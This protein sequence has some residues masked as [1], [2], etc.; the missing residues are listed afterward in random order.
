M[1]IRAREGGPPLHPLPRRPARLGASTSTSGR[2][3]RGGRG[4][5]PR[6]AT[7]PRAS[8]TPTRSSRPGGRARIACWP[9]PRA[10]RA[11]TSCRTSSLCSSRPAADSLLAEAT[12][13]FG[14]HG[15]TAGRWLTDLLRDE[16]GMEADHFDFGR[17]AVYALDP[18]IRPEQRAGV[19]LFARP[20]TPRRATSWRRSRSTCSRRAT[21]RWRSTYTAASWTP[22]R[23]ARPS[24][25]CSRRSSSTTSTTAASPGSC[26][27]RPT[28]RWFRT[29][30]SRPAASRSSTTPSTTASCWRTITWRTRPRRRSSSPTRSPAGA[31]ARPP[32]ARRRRPP[33]RPVCLGVVGRRRRG[34]HADRRRGRRR[35]GPQRAALTT[36]AGS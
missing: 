36:G 14:F 25:A 4:S 31:S 13:R 12:Y 5:A 9:R 23:S 33:R 28:C 15:V 20:E 19:C 8:K 3:A 26:C 16:Y 27:R 22:C 11:S 32:S 24:T 2:S 17:D 10:A 29:R 35:R 34:G 30:C 18:A 6:S 7:P 1:V 21:R